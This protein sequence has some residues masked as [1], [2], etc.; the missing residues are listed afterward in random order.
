MQFNLVISGLNALFALKTCELLNVSHDWYM[1]FYAKIWV[2]QQSN[3]GNVSEKHFCYTVG[4]IKSV[5]YF[6][7]S[8]FLVI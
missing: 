7:S 2:V 1:L 8:F 4:S 6:L 5:K 3:L